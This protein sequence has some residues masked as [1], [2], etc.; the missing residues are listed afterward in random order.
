M[1][2][3]HYALGFSPYR[4]GGLTKYC[5]D[6]MTEQ[7]RNGHQVLLLW[8]G[9]MG[10]RYKEPFIRIKKGKDSI[11]SCELLHPLP[12]PLDEGILDMEEY[13]RKADKK[14]YLNFLKEVKPDV[15]HFHTFMGIHKEFLEAANNLKI[16]T[17]YTTHDYYG[18][19]FKATFFAAGDVCDGDCRYCRTCNETAL[20]IRK[21]RTM[22]SG[23][24][25]Y[26][27][28]AKI[29]KY[30]RKKHRNAFFENGESGNNIEIEDYEL[31]SRRYQKLRAYYINMF[32]TLDVIHFN[33]SVTEKIF[34]KYIR[35]KYSKVIN[36]SNREIGDH[37]V[38][39]EVS[40]E[41]IR[42]SFLGALSPAKGY[43]ML[44]ETL[45][46]LYENGNRNFLLQI[47]DGNRTV[48]EFTK[49]Y[50]RFSHEQLGEIMKNTDILVVP[51]I[52]YETFSLIVLEG[53]S[54]GVPV[55]VS[56]HVGAKDLLEDGTTGYIFQ[57]TK[58][59]LKSVLQKVL[60]SPKEILEN[61]N[62]NIIENLNIK[63]LEEH[64]KEIQKLY[65]S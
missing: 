13:M 41:K 62:K 4:T 52:W 26:L 38:Y 37:K 3:L 56:S 20:S 23:I 45:T 57:P 58:E 28:D 27:K 25:R 17:V 2:I 39:K 53:L 46:E 43:K 31:Q 6:L 18:L 1:R 12:V 33:S 21:I 19:C 32:Q 36:I 61:M 5:E 51:S 49:S 63:D 42:I 15:I 29:V 34:L 14:I 30:L 55:A 64:A 22:Q 60:D 35:P 7:I 47:F 48:N 40:A 44:Q 24:Y 50:D 59:G 11:V 54:Y 16:R 9:R 8:P 65:G 10:C